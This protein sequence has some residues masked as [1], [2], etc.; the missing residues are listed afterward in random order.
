MADNMRIELISVV[1]VFDQ[2]KFT[3][4]FPL[5]GERVREIEATLNEVIQGAEGVS[6]RGPTKIISVPRLQIDILLDSQRIEMRRRFPPPPEELGSEM[7]DLFFAMLNSFNTNVNEIPWVRTGYNFNLTIQTS[8]PAIEKLAQE[9]LSQ[10]FRGKLG[11]PVK[12]AATWLWLDE[13]EAVHW[14]RLEPHRND[15]SSERVTV[16][17]NFTE[18]GGTLASAENIKSKQVAYWTKL[19]DLLHRIGL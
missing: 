19:N 3:R 5:T 6:E 14:L 1:G 13:S 18:E 10:D 11:S 8:G 15:P 9:S 16:V 4:S 2:T 12:G 17:S 7:T